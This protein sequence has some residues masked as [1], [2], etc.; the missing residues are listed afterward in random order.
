MN[1]SRRNLLLGATSTLATGG[2]ITV[3]AAS[4]IPFP[5][6]ITRFT[7]LSG[8]RFVFGYDPVQ[9]RLHPG[10]ISWNDPHLN[11][12]E[13]KATNQ[14][15]SYWMPNEVYH[16]QPMAVD[17]HRVE[18]SFTA[19]WKAIDEERLPSATFIYVGPPYVWHVQVAW[20]YRSDLTPSWQKI[21]FG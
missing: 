20:K 1:V 14:A 2:T 7:T 13:T 9:S 21:A 3:A 5:D 10:L 11:E 8:F 12:W 18:D 15:G 16:K 6:K 17:D 19:Y 4:D